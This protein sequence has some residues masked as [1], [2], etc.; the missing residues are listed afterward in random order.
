MQGLFT[1]VFLPFSFITFWRCNVQPIP[2]GLSLFSPPNFFFHF[3]SILVFSFFLVFF[4]P[5]CP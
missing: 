5:A 1:L 3:I 2:L 4:F